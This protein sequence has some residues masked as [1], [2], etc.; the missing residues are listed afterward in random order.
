MTSW[1]VDPRS[2]LG[3][4]GNPLPYAEAAQANIPVFRMNPTRVRA[5]YVMFEIR[6]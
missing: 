4:Q 6:Q 5:G 2:Q 3:S 1:L